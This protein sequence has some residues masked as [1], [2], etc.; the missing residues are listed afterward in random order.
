MTLDIARSEGA[1][2]R[3]VDRDGA[4]TISAESVADAAVAAALD[5]VVS[6]LAPLAATFVA[7]DEGHAAHF[8]TARGSRLPADELVREARGWHEQ[9]A[10]IGPLAPAAL[11]GVAASVA[12][13]DDVGGARAALGNATLMAAYRRIGAID[14]LRLL[15]RDGRRLRAAI[16]IWRPLRSEPWS[17]AQLRPLEALQPLIEMAYL[18]ALRSASPPVDLLSAPLTP[19]QREVARLLV[20]G[21]GSREVSRA[22]RISTNTVKSHTRAILVKLGV[23]SQREMVLLLRQGRL[24]PPRRR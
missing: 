7:I 5:L 18:A 21:A 15:I 24:D 4:P 10:T 13:L 16:A 2:S 9:L 12:T 20:D 14:D 6:E 11:A 23:A 17:R 22:L 3:D 1:T 19:R 8:R